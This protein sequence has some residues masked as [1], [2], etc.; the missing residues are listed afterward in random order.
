MIPAAASPFPQAETE[1]AKGSFYICLWGTTAFVFTNLFCPFSGAHLVQVGQEGVSTTVSSRTGCTDRQP[2]R[3]S[4]P[5]PLPSRQ[6]SLQ[7][8]PPTEIIF[9]LTSNLN[10]PSCNSG[11]VSIITSSGI[12]KQCLPP[13]ALQL[14]FSPP[15]DLLIARLNK[16]SLSSRDVLQAPDHLGSPNSLDLK[17]FAEQALPSSLPVTAVA[18]LR[19]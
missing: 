2:P 13:S 12:T 7:H 15:Q 14:L 6:Q 5:A 8:C 9:S 18:N 19:F 3:T 1:Y 16:P 10:F 17:L 11:P 4:G